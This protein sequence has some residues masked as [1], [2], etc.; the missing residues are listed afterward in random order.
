MDNTSFTDSDVRGFECKHIHYV[1]S[2]TDS[3]NDL[4]FVKGYVHLHDG[5][6]IPQT[7][8]RENFKRPFWVTRPLHRTHQDKKE[9]EDESKLMRFESTQAKLVTNAAKALGVSAPM[10]GQL[11]RLARSPYLYGCDITPGALLKAHYMA[12]FPD[13]SSPNR[14]AVSDTETDI[15]KN[16]GDPGFEEIIM[17]SITFKD[18]V[19]FAA[20]AEFFQGMDLQKVP[21]L[22][23]AAARKYIG[24]VLDER[25][26]TIEIAIVQNA[27]DVAAAVLQKAH[28]WQPDFLT[29]WNM[30]YDIGKM[31]RALTDH[32]YDLN[33]VWSD[34][35]VPKQYQSYR[36]KQGAKQKVT[37]SGKTMP[38]HPAEQW[39]SVTSP[40]SFFVIDSMCVYLRM[41]IAKGKQPSYALNAILGKELK[42]IQ[43]LHL[44]ELDAIEDGRIWH[45][46]MQKNHKIEYCVYNIFDC[47]SVELLDEKIKD[48]QMQ[49]SAQCEYSEYWKF[50]SQPR[51]TCDDLHFFVQTMEPKKICATTSDEMMTD[52]DLETVNPEGW[53]NTLRSDLLHDEAGLAI[54][55]ELP[56]FHSL[57][58]RD[59]GDLDLASTYPT[60]EKALNLSKETTAN[61]LCSLA[62][63][64]ESLQRAAGINLTGGNVNAVEILTSIFNA[65]TFDQIGAYYRG[66]DIYPPE[67][68]EMLRTIASRTFFGVEDISEER[69]VAT[70]DDED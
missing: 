18:R 59:V 36:F 34:P 21:E 51:R 47:I 20:T 19:F 64:P 63:I 5:R 62:G 14:V 10:N 1:T 56:G 66:E 41:R 65:P 30:E 28:E 46:E 15:L 58:L 32:G 57:L 55:E 25:N 50:P 26:I 29:F 2:S 40:A 3:N 53:I 17:Q 33:Q 35:S 39:H 6:Q 69:T 42:G 27:G 48:L 31:E 49:I 43:K 13:L 12:K 60:L 44:E 70:E 23:Q 24:W 9:W 67:F 37:A 16:P 54:I 68:D 8:Q 11:R 22:I 45:Q 61:E 52:L 4:L 38:L 7:F